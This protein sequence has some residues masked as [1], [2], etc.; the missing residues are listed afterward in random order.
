MHPITKKNLWECLPKPIFEK[1]LSYCDPN[2]RFV[3][4]SFR[5]RFDYACKKLAWNPLKYT[6]SL[7]GSEKDRLGTFLHIFETA[8]LHYYDRTINIGFLTRTK[9][10]LLKILEA[11]HNSKEKPCTECRDHEE[12]VKNGFSLLKRYFEAT[13]YTKRINAKEPDAKAEYRIQV[14]FSDINNEILQAFRGCEI[15]SFYY[16]RLKIPENHAELQDWLDKAENQRKLAEIDQ[17]MCDLPFGCGLPDQFTL[18]SNLNTLKLNYNGLCTLPVALGNLPLTSLELK[19]NAF[20]EIPACIF[21]ISS[22]KSL[23][24]SSNQISVLP[25]GMLNLTNLEQL[26]LENNFLEALPQWMK[27]LI[28][29]ETLKL[30]R[31]AFNQFPF[32]VTQL[33]NL[34]MLSLQNNMIETIPNEIGNLTKLTYLYLGKNAIQ[35]LPDTFMNLKKLYTLFLHK[36]QLSSIKQLNELQFLQRVHLEG[37]QLT[38]EQCQYVPDAPEICLQKNQMDRVDG[39][40][41]FTRVDSLN[42][43]GNGI[44]D[45]S[46]LWKLSNLKLKLLSINDNSI[47]CLENPLR[48]NVIQFWN[49]PLMRVSKPVLTCF[50]DNQPIQQLI[51]ESKKRITAAPS[52]EVLYNECLTLDY[53]GKEHFEQEIE[54]F[55]KLVDKLSQKDQELL[56][57]LRA[58]LGECPAKED[59]KVWGKE[60]LFDKEELFLLAVR[61][62][63]AQFRLQVLYKACGGTLDYQG[64]EQFEQKIERFKA[65]VDQLMPEDQNRLFTIRAELGECPEK[66]DPKVWGKEHLFEKE[67]LFFVAVR[68][69]GGQD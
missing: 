15:L 49:N 37:N 6:N 21:T 7:K 34:V 51:A 8:V 54:G 68:K 22:L 2:V 11:N 45:L 39:F 3:S 40:R 67:E 31:N 20:T 44:T 59:P 5:E 30:S 52:L 17:M 1:I 64:E 46:Q 66:K 63:T 24:M 38:S 65:L 23:D 60:H 48:I 57:T 43:D 28:Q 56:F 69:L 27:D 16:H 32:E 33:T 47:T 62:L 14:N 26:D 10:G 9:A 13:K 35:Q 36:N 55:K 53:Q 42:L 12:L 58:K 19:N 61:G 18:F 41:N 50:Y 29:L 25:E 4:H